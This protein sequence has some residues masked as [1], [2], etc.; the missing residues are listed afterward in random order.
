MLFLCIERMF[1]LT[2]GCRTLDFFFCKLATI[3][4][5]HGTRKAGDD[6]R[7]REDLLFVTVAEDRDMLLR[8]A[9]VKYLVVFVVTLWTMKF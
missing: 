3:I 7:E 5:V 8:N 9:L 4:L 2:N 6:L 1:G